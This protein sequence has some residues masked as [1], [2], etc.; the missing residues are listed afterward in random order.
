[1]FKKI[2]PKTRIAVNKTGIRNFPLVPVLTVSTA[3]TLSACG[4]G[5]GS[6]ADDIDT[7]AAADTVETL[8]PA[9]DT[10]ISGT[11]P[12]DAPD[13]EIPATDTPSDVSPPD[14]PPATDIPTGPATD[15][16]TEI[17][18]DDTT[19]DTPTQETPPPTTGVDGEISFVGV[20]DIDID[21]Q[22]AFGL[23]D[24]TPTPF[25]A[26]QIPE[27]IST[28]VDACQ[29]IP[30]DI[31]A[32][33]DLGPQT[34]LEESFTDVEEEFVI[35]V[36]AGEVI[37]ISSPAG[38]FGELV[39]DDSEPGEFFYEEASELPSGAIPAGTT[40]NIPG[41]T[42]PAVA[43]VPVPAVEFLTDFSPLDGETLQGVEF[44]WT[45]SEN[46]DTNLINFGIQLET[47]LISCFLV[48]DGS[49][50]VP[51]DILNEAGDG[52]FTVFVSRVGQTITVTDNAIVAISVF[53]ELEN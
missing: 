30:F 25:P 8:D 26:S 36:S 10:P 19:V 33:I 38:S 47:S 45:G 6:S 20:I 28:T 49:F 5:S 39:L 11:S 27:G 2:K 32:A 12:A 44:T 46:T 23:F 16:P 40:L 21:R 31:G 37:T 17:D 24:Q 52:T 29:A 53:T 4:G 7:D 50:T 42:F 3:L 1:M 18:P 41:S 14:F 13:S 43:N 9:A 48:D 22:E 15:I 34:P 35:P 51:T